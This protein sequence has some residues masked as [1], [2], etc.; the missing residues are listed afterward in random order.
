VIEV[1]RDHP[2]AIILA[3][4]VSFA[5]FVQT[6]IVTVFVLSYATAQVGIPRNIMLTGLMLGSATMFLVTGPA[7]ALADRVGAR[8]IALA[9]AFVSCLLAFPFFWLIDTGSP[10][11]IWI[12]MSVC[13]IGNSLI[14]TVSG[15]LTAELFPARLRYS[16]ISFSQQMA[17]L[18]GGALTPIIATTLVNWSGG[19][20]WPVAAYVAMAA[21]V[22]FSAI[23]FASKKYRVSI[24]DVLTRVPEH[25]PA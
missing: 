1:L 3:M 25:Q 16:G 13:V 5:V 19:K 7:G 23:Y 9:G 17:G 18:P 22:S 6:Y 21:L 4:G 2:V 8:A 24:Q 14:Y 12:A 11:L 20:S 10:V 15:A